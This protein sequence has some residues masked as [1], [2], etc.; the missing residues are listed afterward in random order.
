ML[1]Q[2]S[3]VRAP[4]DR[5]KIRFFTLSAFKQH[6]TESDCRL[7]F[8]SAVYSPIEMLSISIG[9]SGASR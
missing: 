3:Y 1:C 4:F 6:L 7:R 9:S 5:A 2:L 8:P